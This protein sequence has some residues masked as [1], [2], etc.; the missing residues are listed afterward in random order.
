MKDNA[1]LQ[2]NFH[3]AIFVATCREA[4]HMT[5]GELAE[6]SNMDEEA[7][8]RIEHAISPASAVQLLRLAQSL[9]TTPGKI[10]NDF[11]PDAETKAFFMLINP[12][13]SSSEGQ[14]LIQNYNAIRD[15]R[16]RKAFA[17]VLRAAAGRY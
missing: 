9:N 12:K 6:R 3:I 15:K 17:R 16:L 13:S 2:I 7:M 8:Y 10:L 11:E 5:R 4:T 1:F 14:E